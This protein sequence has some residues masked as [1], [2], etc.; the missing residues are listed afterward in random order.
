VR[1]CK[2]ARGRP[3]TA[4]RLQEERVGEEDRLAV[5]AEAGERLRARGDG[6]ERS[7]QVRPQRRNAHNVA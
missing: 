5:Q 1:Q 7:P 2:T 4:A 6:G 3:I